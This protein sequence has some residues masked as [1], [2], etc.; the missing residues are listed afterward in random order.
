MSINLNIEQLNIGEVVSIKYGQT[1]T[2]ADI[3]VPDIKPDILKI[4]DISGDVCIKQHVMQNDRAYVQGV[5]KINILYV[6]DGDV[7]GKI[8]SL[9]TSQ[10][11]NHSIDIVGATPDMQIFAEAEGESYDFSLINSRKI[12]VRAVVG[13]GVKVTKAQEV[14]IATGADKNIQI[15]TE[16]IMISSS[17]DGKTEQIIIREQTELPSGKPSIGEILKMRATGV[18]TE[19]QMIDG[20][21]IAKG[22]VKL[23]IL[24]CAEDETESIQYLENVL[25]FSEVFDVPGAVEDMEGEVEYSIADVYSEI[26]E[27]SDGEPRCVGVECVIDAYIKGTE[28]VEL[29]SISDAYALCGN[30]KITREGYNIEQL[31]DN[32]TAQISHKDIVKIQSTLPKPTQIYDVCSEA[33]VNKITVE[34][35]CINV[36]GSVVTHILYL[37]DDDST[38]VASIEHSSEFTHTLESSKITNDCACDAKIFVDHVSYNMSGDDEIELRLV[39]C[40]GVKIVK[41]GRC[42]VVTEIE[43]IENECL[44]K[45]SSIIIYFVQPG[46]TLWN[47]ARRYHTTVK[48]IMEMNCLENDK[49]NIGQQIKMCRI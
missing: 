8:K 6:P 32:L 41:T 37:T 12:N 25:P 22:Q 13:I 26:R 9:S 14:K 30:V 46:D 39:I 28:T 16:K 10:E 17:T 36:H 29:P 42:E 5:V 11:F 1:M 4:L 20:K 34:N 38:P 23:A 43:V 27:D 35:S 48:D 15:K 7:V 40:L 21:A 2:E 19:V 3:I 44:E 45:C 33:K 47:I 31:I 18:S 49:L 24:Y